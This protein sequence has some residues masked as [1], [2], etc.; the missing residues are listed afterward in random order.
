M[1]K[2]YLF[3]LLLLIASSVAAQ[4]S[5]S[6]M[7][8]AALE[9]MWGAE[10]S[11]GYR[12]ALNL[13][14]AAFKR[15]P[16]SIDHLG[17]YKASVL[18]GEL[19]EYDKAFAYLTPVA[20]VEVDEFGNPGWAY[21]VGDY[22]SSEYENLLGDP[23]WKAMEVT[24]QKR[25]QL[26]FEKLKEAE[27]E[28][29]ASKGYDFKEAEPT[30]ALYRE[31]RNANPYLSKVQQSYSISLPV[32]DTATTS[33]F[34]HLPKTY[35][36]AR[37]Y[38]VLI[39]L[40]GA[41][42]YNSFKSYQNK[43]VLD[44]WNRYYR[45]YAEKYGVIL[46][47][48]QASRQFNWMVPDD[49]FFLIPN[50][51]KQLKTGINVD[52]DKVFLSGH[53]NGATGS[54]SYLM[55]QPTGF[56]GFY[57]FNTYPRVFT[58]G[59]F[60][61]NV[62]NRSFINFSTDQ[63]YYYPPAANDKLSDLMENLSADYKDHRYNGFPHWFPA[64][65]E[66]EPAYEILFEDLDQRKRE[67]FPK[68]ISWEFD[69]EKYG[70]IDWLSEIKLDTFASPSTWHE[71]MNFK[72]DQWLDYDDND[73]LIVEKVDR[74]AFPMPRKSG[75]II[76]RFANNIFTIET[77]RIKSFQIRLSPEMIN[78]KKKVQVFI[79]GKLCHNKKVSFNRSYMLNS[80]EQERDRT[81]VWV[82]YIKVQL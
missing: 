3:V 19:K 20:E 52:D 58:G 37:K 71:A 24:A 34:V 4:D 45:D 80:F 46:V 9:T 62:L 78:V 48:P 16:D 77:S 51:V 47:F 81:Q 12:D 66:S 82:N 31:L 1:K 17:L 72:I 2:C 65:D 7:S 69:D 10:D 28:F 25:K 29:F 36:P 54:F 56:A 26:F 75:K 63:D 57:G 42:R 22:S 59:T 79:N 21:I 38:P 61:E 44:G 67:A 11:T 68:S 23:R 55:K 14:E 30:K 76:A 73:S 53:S 15:F 33:Y 70:A 60:I 5:Y 32:N 64:F 41:V 27:A 49:G 35:Q 43:S 8:Q 39:F 18:A 13:Y 50:I 74:V 6:A 40:H